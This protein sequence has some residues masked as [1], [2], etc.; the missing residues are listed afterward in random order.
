MN[1][2]LSEYLA[3]YQQASADKLLPVAARDFVAISS[4]LLLGTRISFARQR[5]NIFQH[6]V[7]FVLGQDGLEGRHITLA[8][9]D[10]LDEFFIRFLL[11]L[12]RTQIRYLQALADGGVAAPILPVASYAFRFEHIRARSFSRKG[13][14]GKQKTG[15]Q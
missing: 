9:G 15:N 14:D 7:D 11:D 3:G 10:R 6:R 8:L 1:V 2:Y 5:A 12:L 13:R 4:L